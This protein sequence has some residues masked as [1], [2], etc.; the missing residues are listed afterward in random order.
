MLEHFIAVAGH[1]DGSDLIYYT[2]TAHECCAEQV[3]AQVVAWRKSQGLALFKDT[4]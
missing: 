4:K 3:I 1:P 2:G